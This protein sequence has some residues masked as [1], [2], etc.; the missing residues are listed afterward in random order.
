MAVKG[1]KE[2]DDSVRYEREKG[3]PFFLTE[4]KWPKWQAFKEAPGKRD[5]RSRRWEDHEQI[6]HWAKDRS[7]GGFGPGPRR[8]DNWE[9]APTCEYMRK[10]AIV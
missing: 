9:V 2:W 5:M 7:L 6:W 3:K 4:E 10:C 1:G 8:A